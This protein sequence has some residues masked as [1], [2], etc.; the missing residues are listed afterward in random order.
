MNDTFRV[1]LI[2]PNAVIAQ[3]DATALVAV[4]EFG[5]F[6][7]LPGHTEYLSVLRPGEL[8]LHVAGRIERYVVGRGFAEVGPK[9]VS[10]LGDT[11]ERVESLDAESIRQELET[12]EE[13][14]KSEDPLGDEYSRLLDRVERNR[15][16]L[17]AIE[18]EAS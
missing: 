18:G 6:G 12:N 4:G 7:V 11:I 5:Q 13:R 2:T 10:I 16:R 1:E 14:L 17:A 15:A 9:S 3:A 8:R